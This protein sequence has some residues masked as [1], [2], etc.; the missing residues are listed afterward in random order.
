LWDCIVRILVSLSYICYNKLI[1]DNL[2]QNL[3]GAGF[4]RNPPGAQAHHWLPLAQNEYQL[5]RKFIIRGVDPNLS[6]HGEFMDV[7]KHRIIHGKGTTG[8]TGG[9][10]LV[11]QW[12]KFLLN[13]V[14]LVLH[15]FMTLGIV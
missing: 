7:E 3:I 10:V 4:P 15:K 12:D 5:E 8:W 9:D 6:I 2:G 14:L 13:L 1:A 11:Y